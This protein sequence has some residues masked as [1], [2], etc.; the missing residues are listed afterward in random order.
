MPELIAKPAFEPVVLTK[1]GAQL[2]LRDPGPI[3][4]IAMFPGGEKL[5]AKSLKALGLS[6][7]EPGQSLTKG[8]ARILWTGRDQAFLIGVDAPVVEGAA[9]TDQS[10]GWA[11]LAL[12]GAGAEA[13]LSR[14]VAL[15]LRA[16]AFPIG[17]T[18]RVA[19]NHMSMVLSRQADGFEILVFRSMARSAWHE[20]AEVMEKLEARAV[21]KV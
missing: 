13:V 6:F 17:T 9:V 11:C 12:T 8:E 15:D 18:A 21:A 2:T 1:G 3:T 14:L 20:L 10:D 7:P 19:L 4:S 16:S 5:V